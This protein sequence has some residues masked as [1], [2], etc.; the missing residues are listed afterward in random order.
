MDCKASAWMRYTLWAAAL[1]SFVWG[2]VTVFFPALAFQWSGIEQPNYPEMW[3]CLGMVVG[4]YGVAYAVAGFDPYRHWPVVLGGLLGKIFGPIGFLNAAMHGRLPWRL[5]IVNV[6][7]D[8]IWWIPFTAILVGA[9]VASLESRRIASPEVRKMA[10]RARTQYG[11]TLLQ[12]SKQSPLLF[13]FLRHAGCTFCRETLADLAR[14]RARIEATGTRIILIHMSPE[15]YALT[16]FAKYGLANL[17]RVSDPHRR[18]YRAF[19]LGQ[20]SFLALFGPKVIWRGMIASIIGRHGLGPLMGDGFQM[21]GAFLLYH[22]EVLRSYQHVSVADRPNY[23]ELAKVG[24][25]QA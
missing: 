15:D 11:D 5:G 25:M 22:G 4:V 2:A 9:Y 19:G 18:L 20:G 8:F 21:P 3:Q 17:A 13:V 6:V 14:Q 24:P 1:Y 10:L 16:F 23:V 7:N 12:L